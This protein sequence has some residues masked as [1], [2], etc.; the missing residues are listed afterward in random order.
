LTAVA[1]DA[2]GNTTTSTGVTVTVTDVTAP[3][4]PAGLHTTATSSSAISLAWTA[5]TDNVAVSSYKIYRNGSLI[6]SSASASFTD[7]GV[8]VGATY[9]YTVSALDAAANE[10][11][12]SSVLA[13]LVPDTVAP[14]ASITAPAAGNTVSGT[15]SFTGTANDNVGVV[16]VQ[17]SVDGVSVGAEDTSSPYGIAWDSISTANGSHAITAVARDA[18]GNTTT[19][20]GVTV[21]L[22]NGVG[23][24]TPPSVPA[25]LA[26]TTVTTSSVSLSWSASTDDTG[27][28]GYKLYRGGTLIAS[29]SGTSYTDSGL[30]ATTTYSYTVVAYD[31]QNNTSAQSSAVIVKTATPPPSCKIGDINCDGKVNFTDISAFL[32]RYNTSNSTCD[33][34][35]SG[36]V[37]FTDLSILLSKYGS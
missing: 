31:A 26:S 17:F 19:S 12:Q 33:L 20:T 23:D 1:R 37:D 5:S 28:I 22:N 30:A 29:P 25:G 7:S 13:V 9:N 32:T 34:N 11:A 2:A 8:S 24:T 6:G 16:G 35:H 18:A 14:T 15:V 36:K 4:I 3:S 27:V 10:S 21:T